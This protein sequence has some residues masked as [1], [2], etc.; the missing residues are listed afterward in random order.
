MKSKISEV[1]VIVTLFFAFVV[2]SSVSLLAQS[3]FNRNDGYDFTGEHYL[4]VAGSDPD[5]FSIS[6]ES[7]SDFRLFKLHIKR[8]H[9]TLGPRAKCNQYRVDMNSDGTWEQDWTTSDEI[10]VSYNYPN[11]PNGISAN[12]TITVEIEYA[13]YNGQTYPLN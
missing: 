12:N 10:T 3:V 9:L 2:C 7:N 6:I 5:N 13:D 8:D 11:P 4:S 1:S